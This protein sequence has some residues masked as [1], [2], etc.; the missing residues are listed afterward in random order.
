MLGE[1]TRNE[2]ATFVYE[3]QV[4][5]KDGFIKERFLLTASH[6]AHIDNLSKR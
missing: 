4:Y 2:F 1:S 3:Q 5:I 6:I